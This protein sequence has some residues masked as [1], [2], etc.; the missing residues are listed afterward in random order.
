MQ[1][2]A[3]KVKSILVPRLSDTLMLTLFVKHLSHRRLTEEKGMKQNN[4]QWHEIQ[5][6]NAKHQ[7]NEIKMERPASRIRVHEIKLRTIRK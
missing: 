1:R 5:I 4:Q 2:S 3:F 7:R 6:K